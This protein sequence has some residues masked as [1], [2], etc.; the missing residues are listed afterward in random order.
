MDSL[1]LRFKPV[2]LIDNISPIITEFSA[3]RSFQSLLLSM[4]KK[5]KIKIEIA[6]ANKFYL[7][8]KLLGSVI[9]VVKLEVNNKND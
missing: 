4:S 9:N 3:F 8:I 6:K 7:V 1:L 5:H 2:F